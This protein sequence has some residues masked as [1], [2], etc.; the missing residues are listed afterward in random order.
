MLN[1]RMLLC[2]CGLLVCASP[3]YAETLYVTDRILLGLHELPDS[4]SRLVASL[5]S[6]SN[7]EVVI[8]QDDFVQVKTD[9]GTTGWAN[10]AFLM[11]KPPAQQLLNNLSQ[12]HAQLAQE[13]D[14]LRKSLAQSEQALKD[15]EAALKQAMEKAEQEPAPATPATEADNGQE[16]EAARQELAALRAQLET[17]Q[18][19]AQSA[20]DVASPDP[21]V[22]SGL[23]QENKALRARIE[24]ALANLSGE[25][26]PAPEELA[27]IRPDFPIWYFAWI[28]VAAIVGF[29][30]GAVW[31]DYRQRSRLGGF[32]I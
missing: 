4:T 28:V 26:A 12:Q 29:V 13:R 14:Q 20:A 5:P 16:L 8:K 19:A 17:L 25:A 24:L 6:G 18:A 2:L 9:D 32:R 15:K 11:A 31:L 1:R 7:V 23:E 21:A 27:A 3:L 22:I 30:G 10:V